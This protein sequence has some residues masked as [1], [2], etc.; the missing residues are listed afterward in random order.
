[1]LHHSPRKI[2]TG[3]G[4]ET[5]YG[6][7]SF[8]PAGSKHFKKKTYFIRLKSR[9]IHNIVELLIIVNYI[10]VLFSTFQTMTKRANQRKPDE[11]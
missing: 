2:E 10:A 9:N 4:I 8:R 3:V 5:A 7:R 11:I 6:N 1:M